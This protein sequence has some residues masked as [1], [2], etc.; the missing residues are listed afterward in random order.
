[1]KIQRKLMEGVIEKLNDIGLTVKSGYVPNKSFINGVYINSGNIIYDTSATIS[2]VLHE[3]GH[4]AIV[5]RKYHSLCMG[6]MERSAKRIFNKLVPDS[7]DYRK[8]LHT[9]DQEATAWA[10]AFGKSIN[11]D[12]SLIIN[13][14]DYD[15]EG[16]EIGIMLDC[17]SYGGING[18]ICAGMINNVRQYPK[19]NYWVQQ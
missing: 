7:V 17:R 2:D 16:E 15:G 10:Y 18:L 6:D 19:L 3:C 5:P 4:V 8:M 13:A 9:S 12:T 11:L 1:M 14:K